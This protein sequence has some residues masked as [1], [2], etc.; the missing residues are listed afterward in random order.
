ME[1]PS[2]LIKHSLA[3][4]F[5]AENQYYFNTMHI[6]WSIN[7]DD[8]SLYSNFEKKVFKKKKKLDR[9]YILSQAILPKQLQ[10]FL[11]R[12]SK[13]RIAL[14][15]RKTRWN[16]KK[17]LS[18]LYS[19]SNPSESCKKPSSYFSQKIFFKALDDYIFTPIEKRLNGTF[20]FLFFYFL[21]KSLISSSR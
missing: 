12:Y 21:C 6:L 9:E 5:A 10:S 11:K 4:F 7:C 19:I 14:K 15:T 3:H 20:S 8:D 18:Q 16:C 13:T 17:I 2:Y 1:P